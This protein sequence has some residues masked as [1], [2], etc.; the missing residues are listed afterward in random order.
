MCSLDVSSI[1]YRFP[2]KQ[3]QIW[4]LIRL[5][6]IFMNKNKK[7]LPHELDVKQGRLERP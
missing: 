3:M 6:W 1:C 5:Q 2:T 4:N 7:R